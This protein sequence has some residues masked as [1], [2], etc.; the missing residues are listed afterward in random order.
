MHM[1]IQQNGDRSGY[2]L[3]QFSKPFQSIQEMIQFYTR[4]SLPVKGAE[5]ITLRNPICDQLL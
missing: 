5:H 4:N 3:G 1:K 2:I